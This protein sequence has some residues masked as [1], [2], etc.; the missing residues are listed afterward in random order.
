MSLLY[1]DILINV[2]GRVIEKIIE[3]ILMGCNEFASYN[4]I[5]TE[6]RK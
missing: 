6:K 3:G 1:C 5:C 2:T 4:W